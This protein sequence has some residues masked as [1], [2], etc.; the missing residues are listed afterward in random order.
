MI[1]TSCCMIP[2]VL[3]VPMVRR[4]TTPPWSSPRREAPTSYHDPRPRWTT[5]SRTSPQQDDAIQE[6]LHQTRDTFQAELVYSR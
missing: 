1:H 4:S 6:A 3:L 5:T 2:F